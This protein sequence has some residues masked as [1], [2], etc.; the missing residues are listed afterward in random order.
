MDFVE[1][2]I[3]KFG[4]EPVVIGIRWEEPDLIEKMVYQAIAEGKP[5][6]EEDELTSEELKAFKDGRLF[7]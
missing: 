5:Y 6:N 4:V 1:K 2:H 7:F 3:E